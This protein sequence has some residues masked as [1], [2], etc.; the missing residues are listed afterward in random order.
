MTTIVLN[1]S[2]KLRQA[3]LWCSFGTTREE[4]FM[5]RMLCSA[6]R[7]SHQ[8]SIRYSWPSV[9]ERRFHK[10]HR[11]DR[12]DGIQADDKNKRT[13]RLD[14]IDRAEDKGKSLAI[15]I[16]SHKSRI[17]DFIEQL[18]ASGE[19]WEAVSKSIVETG[20]QCHTVHENEARRALELS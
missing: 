1:C 3:R 6:E 14:S 19:C 13:Y 12:R 15:D 4:L 16:Q 18:V 5:R 7:W 2:R 17:A 10:S 11:H 8:V 20:R 9:E